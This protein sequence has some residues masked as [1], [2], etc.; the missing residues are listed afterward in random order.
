[1]TNNAACLVLL[2]AIEVCTNTVYSVVKYIAENIS[3][4]SY[5]KGS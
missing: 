5:K 3:I 1:M 4:Y 2:V